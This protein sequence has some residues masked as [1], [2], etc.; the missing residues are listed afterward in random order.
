MWLKIA[1]SVLVVAAGAGIGFSL[2]GRCSERPRQLRQAVSCL[3]ALA[4]Y[5]GY[6]SLPLGEA[7]VRAAGGVAGPAGDF[8]RRTAAVLAERG[9]QTPAQAMEEALAAAGP[10]LAWQRPEREIMLLLGANLGATNREEQQKYLALVT[11]QLRRLEQE[12]TR[13]R[14]QNARMYRYL[15]VCGGLAVAILLV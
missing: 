3:S 13:L 12:A 11:D 15:G 9:W 4:S 5:I 6:A 8:F 10:T 2:A 1:G 14:D 7:L